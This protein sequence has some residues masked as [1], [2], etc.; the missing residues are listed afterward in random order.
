MYNS[1]TGQVS[2]KAADSLYLTVADIEWHFL[3][4][5]TTLAGVKLGE[6]VKLY[7]YLQHKEDSMIL[8]GFLSEKERS[9][10]LSLIKVNG[11]GPKVAIKI[12]GGLTP[13]D[14]MAALQNDDIAAL[15]RLPGLG[16]ATAQ[17]IILA[18]RGKLVLADN[19]VAGSADDELVLSLVAM[20]FD[21]KRT[22]QVVKELKEQLGAVEES[23]LIK[24]AIIRLSGG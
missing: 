17:K 1:F 18:L 15:S 9:L 11:V 14:F 3:V 23:R 4:S 21:K 8:Y 2:G 24:Q 7:S 10:F 5:L 6:R 13:D 22:E 12:V 19:D 16:K 20:G